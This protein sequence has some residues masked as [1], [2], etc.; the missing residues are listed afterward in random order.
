MYSLKDDKSIIIKGVDKGAALIVWE[1]ED[2][3]KETIKQL[4]EKEVY[5]EEVPKISNVLVTT[6]FKSLAKIRK[7]AD[8]SQDSY[9]LVKDPKSARFYLLPKIHKRLS[10]VPGR[11][12]IS[13]TFF[14]NVVFTPKIFLHF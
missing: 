4:E 14:S 1:R 12:V 8:L 13:N 2:Y 10:D 7:R 3:L 11:P 6:I 9:Y 5:L